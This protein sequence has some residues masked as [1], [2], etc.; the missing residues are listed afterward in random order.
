M[1]KLSVGAA[2]F[3]WGLSYAQSTPAIFTAAQVE[4]GRAIYQTECQHCHTDKLT[5]RRGDPDE[6]PLL[7]AMTP[8]MRKSVEGNGR[9]PPLVGPDFLR[10]WGPQTTKDLFERI[11]IAAGPDDPKSL[12]LTA[13]ILQFNGAK[14]G[15][16][17]ITGETAVT[18]DAA[19]GR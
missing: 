7:S 10:K 19:T 11:K 16:Q 12:N 1:R 6:R 4:A 5:G 9:I 8:D 2:L 14:A 3:G 18:V 15:Q 17:P 13:W